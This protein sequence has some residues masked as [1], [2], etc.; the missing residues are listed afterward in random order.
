MS[1]PEIAEIKV[2]EMSAEDICE[3]LRLG[4]ETGISRWTADSYFSEITGR[5]SSA[6]SI[7]NNGELCGFLIARLIITETLTIHI[8]EAEILNIAVFKSFQRK[9]FGQK[10]LEAFLK[11]VEL[12]NISE[13]WLEVRES[14]LQA[15][16]FYRKNGFSKQFERKNYYSEPPGNALVM[17]K[18]I[19]SNES[20]KV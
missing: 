6:L 11:I 1:T 19:V 8:K 14:N 5:D 16:N 4:E 2:F 3:V 15:I 18:T 10:L 7:K 17:R 9:G 12:K 13:V 20:P